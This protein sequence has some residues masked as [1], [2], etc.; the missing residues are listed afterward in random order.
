MEIIKLFFSLIFLAGLGYTQSEN[1]SLTPT[2]ILPDGSVFKTW[3]NTTAYTKT[4][5]VDQQHPLAS[6]GNPGTVDM[7]LRTINKAAQMVQAGEQVRIKSGVYREKVIPKNSGEG[8]DKMISYQAETGAEVII[9][10]SQIL[11]KNW[12]RS[13]NPEQYSEKLWMITL[14]DSIFPEG[15]PFKLQNASAADIEIMPWATEWIGRVPYTLCRGMVFQDGRRL[16]QL[17]LYE[18]LVRI[19]GSFWINSSGTVLHLHPLDRADPNREFIEV[20]VVPHLFKPDSTDLA[21]IEVKG[22]TF[23]HAGNGFP[24]TGTG[25]L[26]TMGGH[27]WIIAENTF[28]DINSVAVEI[29]AKSVETPN[30]DLSRKDWQRTRIS[31]GYVIVRNNV[32]SNCGTGG[33]Q[34]YVNQNALVENNH[35]Y[36]IGWQDVERYWECAAIKLLVAN[37]TVVRRNLIHDVEAASGIWLDWDNKYSRITQNTL[38]DLRMCCNGALFVEASQLPNT[39]DHNIVMDIHGIAIY[40]GDSDSL[41]IAHNLIGRCSNTGVVSLVATDRRLNN[42]SFTARHNRVV[43]NIFYTENAIYFGDLE[44]VS[45]QNVFISSS[46]LKT[47]QGEGFDTDSKVIP[48]EFILDRKTVQLQIEWQEKVPL[49]NNE[50]VFKHDFFNASRGNQTAVG[51][52]SEAQNKPVILNIDPRRH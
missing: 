51:P 10:G 46:D 6:D 12:I 14:P 13:K 17:G 29:G 28:K 37:R 31:P 34:G 33:I 9:K 18:D 42:R 45:N 3:V 44:N 22:V 47:R 2:V 40:G 23:M 52:F 35:I 49:F 27:H 20:T 16:V 30:R 7:P 38:F 32:I 25:A 26:F 41:L 21:Y 24:R 8:P 5:V 48:F 4:I 1:L 50:N 15:S 11:N 39:I 43:K 19:P 36:N